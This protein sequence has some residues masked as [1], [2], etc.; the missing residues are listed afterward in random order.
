MAPDPP[1]VLV[2]ERSIGVSSKAAS[3]REGS[4][5]EIEDE[6][7]EGVDTKAKTIRRLRVRILTSIR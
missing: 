3:D 7:G 4:V 6:E 5:I 2:A 1:R